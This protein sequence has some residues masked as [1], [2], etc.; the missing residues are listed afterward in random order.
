MPRYL[1][2]GLALMALVFAACSGGSD[3]ND[4]NGGDGDETPAATRTKAPSTGGGDLE[5]HEDELRETAVDAYKAIFGEGALDAY[6]FA[7]ADFKEKCSLDDFISIIAFVKIFLGNIDAEDIDVEV[8][9]VRYEDGK[10]FVEIAGTIKGE[11]LTAGDESDDFS[12]YWI[13]EDGQWKWGTDDDDPCDTSINA[14][15]DDATPA[16]GPGSSRAEPAPLGEPVDAGDLRVTVLTADLDAADQ[17]ADL[18]DFP[19]TPVPGR[20]TVLARVMVEHIGEDPDETVQ[21]YESDFKITGSKNIIY[22]SFS[23]D[24]SCGFLE[25]ALQGEMFPG[26]QLEGYVCFQVPEDET[27]LLLIAEPSFSFGDEGR[28]FFALE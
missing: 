1:L 14:G 23:D 6:K 12:D 25:E 5:E 8:T 10:A 24:T 9:G 11:E 3:K 28:R 13:Y 17:L 21:V 7:S 2:P 4:D 16:T 15:G 20:R 27:D 26:G 22:D 18:G 19:S